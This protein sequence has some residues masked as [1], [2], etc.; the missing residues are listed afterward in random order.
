[1]AGTDSDSVAAASSDR[2]EHVA[3]NQ[4]RGRHVEE[5]KVS[6]APCS[7]LLGVVHLIAAATGPPAARSS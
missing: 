7:D 1:M 2:P 4:I 6:S 3:F 5:V